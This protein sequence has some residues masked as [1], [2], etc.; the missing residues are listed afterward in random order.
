MFVAYSGD[1]YIREEIEKLCKKHE[2]KTIIETGTFKGKTTLALSELAD[3]VHTIEINPAYYNQNNFTNP[4][5]TKHQGSSPEVLTKILGSVKKPC[6]FYLDAHWYE[7]WPLL[8]E[9]KVIGREAKNSI[10]VIH[11]CFVP[12]RPN[13]GYDTY[14]GQR[15][16]L[17]YIMP[18]L[19]EI[20]PKGYAY[21]Y[22]SVSTGSNRGVI[23][24][25]P[26]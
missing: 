5:I 13:L 24:I 15:L 7:Y 23:Y 19:K 10:I 22:N 18:Y 9:L 3:E 12:G 6:L 1:F 26:R 17:E 2:V 8:D 25:Y 20:Y 21:H 11:D 14:K 16:D 4:K